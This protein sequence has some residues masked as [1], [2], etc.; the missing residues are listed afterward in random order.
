M[1][2]FTF[3]PTPIPPVTPAQ[4]E[5]QAAILTAG[6]AGF[7][8]LLGIL[9]DKGIQ[10]AVTGPGGGSLATSPYTPSQPGPTCGCSVCGGS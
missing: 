7:A 4:K 2:R 3:R 10:A 9:A 6:A 8:L 5:K 1:Q